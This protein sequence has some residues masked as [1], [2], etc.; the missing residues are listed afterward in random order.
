M[1]TGLMLKTAYKENVGKYRV[2]KWF[3]PFKS[4]EMMID[5]KPRPGHPSMSRKN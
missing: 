2:D 1:E 3:S 5:N 4:G